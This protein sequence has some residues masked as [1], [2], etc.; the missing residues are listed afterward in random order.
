EEFDEI[1]REVLTALDEFKA[2]SKSIRR[3]SNRISETEQQVLRESSRIA[4]LEKRLDGLKPE[5]KIV[6]VGEKLNH[7]SSVVDG[8][9]GGIEEVS[10]KE[11]M[12]RKTQQEAA[13]LNLSI[14]EA[15]GQIK[16]ISHERESLQQIGQKVDELSSVMENVEVRLQDITAKMG[17]IENAE[18]RIA[19]LSNFMEDVN[20]KMKSL[21]NQESVIDL[22]NQRIADLRFLLT[23]VSGKVGALSREKGSPIKQLPF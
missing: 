4:S 22:A 21:S 18:A 13:T 7:F 14:Q 10:K 11:F 6:E 16:K 3:I 17:I 15:R 9:R 2:R 19:Q 12:V 20:A 5:E 1:G 8:V 23:E